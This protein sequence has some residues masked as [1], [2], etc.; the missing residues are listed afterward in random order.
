MVWTALPQHSNFNKALRA[1]NSSFLVALSSFFHTFSALRR[2]CRQNKTRTFKNTLCPA[3]NLSLTSWIKIK[4]KYMLV[5]AVKKMYLWAQEMTNTFPGCWFVF[6]RLWSVVHKLMNQLQSRIH[7]V[8]IHLFP[9]KSIFLKSDSC[10][11]N[12]NAVYNEV[13][14]NN[15]NWWTSWR[16]MEGIHQR[17][18]P[19]SLGWEPLDPG[20]H[21]HGQ[22]RTLG[23]PLM[24]H[25]DSLLLFLLFYYL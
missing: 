20:G 15:L 17:L 1:Q 22:D 21:N 3:T 16:P 10:L 24:G 14:P 18:R 7:A 12:G 23:S 2:A 25:E 13:I 8:I 9:W 11:W 5:V 6:F 19:G 4:R